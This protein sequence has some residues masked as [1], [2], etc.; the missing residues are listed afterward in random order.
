MTS[1]IVRIPTDDEW[2]TP[3]G[4][5]VIQCFGGNIF[6]GG[7]P[8]WAFITDDPLQVET[9]EPVVDRCNSVSRA[10]SDNPAENGTYV[11]GEYHPKYYQ[12][13]SGFQVWDVIRAF[14]LDY[15][16]GTAAAYILRAGRKPS[17]VED[18]DSI[19]S[20]LRKAYTVLGERLRDLE[21]ETYPLHEVT[22]TEDTDG[23]HR[24][25]TNLQ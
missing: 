7:K 17:D 25:P 21:A 4:W 8:L 5:R 22:I 13:K 19:F 24:G 1:R 2:E 10:V 18:S 23:I 14:E 12:G 3:S 9:E 6:S 20:D 11:N 15:W 16:T